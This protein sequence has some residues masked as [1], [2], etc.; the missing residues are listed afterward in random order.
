MVNVFGNE[1]VLYVKTGFSNNRTIIEDSYFTAPYKIAKPFYNY[2][3]NM[4]EVM[5]M[6][7]SAGVMEGDSYLTEVDVGRASSLSLQG[8]SYTKIHKMNNGYAKQ[9]NLFYVQEDACFDYDPKPSIPFGDSNFDSESICY[10]YRGAQ[11]L[12]SEIIACGRDKS[13]ERF[14]FKRF[15]SHNKVFYCNDLIFADNQELRPDN[16]VLTE[17][18]FF[19]GYTH[20]ATVAYFHDEMKREA[21]LERLFDEIKE[22]RDVEAGISTTYKYGIIIRILANS[23]DYLENIIVSIRDVIYNIKKSY[24]T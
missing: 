23:S 10:L 2:E 6:S 14:N 9:K 20:Q 19:E 5:V 18:G 12:Y 24:C 17:L 11:Y 16:Q 13:G 22:Y 4:A 8:Q 21:L 7:A 3:R 15:K 1:S